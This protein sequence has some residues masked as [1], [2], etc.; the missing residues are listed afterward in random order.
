MTRESQGRDDQENQ[1]IA[2]YMDAIERGETLDHDQFLAQYPDIADELALFIQSESYF[3]RLSGT[4]NA[5]LEVSTVAHLKQDTPK[6]AQLDL[7]TPVQKPQIH[8]S[9]PVLAR[10]G[11]YELI[12]EIARGGMGVVFKAWQMSLKRFV[13]IKMILKGHLAS[14]DDVQRFQTEALAAAQLEHPGIVRIYEVNEHDGL[15]Y[16]AMAFVDGQSL[17]KRLAEG[18][19]EPRTA[20]GIVKTVCMAVQYAH[21]KGVIHRDLKPG[22]ILIDRLGCPHVTDFGLAKLMERGPDLTGTGQIL[23]TPSYMSPEQAAPNGTTVGPLSDVYSLGAILYCLLTGRPPF[24]AANDLETLV[25]VQKQDPIPPRQFNLKIPL[26][27]ETIVLKSLDKSPER[28]FVSA[29]G[30]ADELTRYLEGQPILARRISRT[31]RFWRWCQ[32]EPRVA[33]L[34]A[35]LLMVL[36]AGAVASSCFAVNERQR[37]NAVAKLAK[38]ESDALVEVEAQRKKALGQAEIARRNENLANERADNLRVFLAQKYFEHGVSEYD[39]GRPQSGITDLTRA[40]AMTSSKNPLHA[41]YRRVLVDRC[42]QGGKQLLPPL[43]HTGP[44]YVVAFSPDGTR[45]LT[46]S[47]DHLARIWDAVTG[48]PIGK[49][50]RHGQAVIGAAFSPDGSL[51]VTRSSAVA[52]LWRADNCEAVGEA[53]EHLQHINCVAFSPDGTRVVTGSDDKTARLF[54]TKSGT[55]IAE[56]MKHDGA[57]YCVAFSPDGRTVA[58]GSGVH[59]KIGTARLWDVETASPVGL[60]MRHADIVHSVCFSPDGSRLLTGSQDGDAQVWNAKSGQLTGQ[61]FAT[62]FPVGNAIFSPDGTRVLTHDGDFGLGY[63]SYF[64]RLWDAQTGERLGSLM[65]H[66]GYVQSIAFSPDGTRI[67]TGSRNKS[68]QVWDANTGKPVGEPML[69]QGYVGSVAFS[70]DGASVLSGSYDGTARLWSSEPNLPI[71]G[72]FPHKGFSSDVAF[73]PDGTSFLVGAE[74]PGGR[75]TAQMAYLRDARTGALVGQVMQHERRVLSVAYS[76]DGSLVATGSGDWDELGVAQLWDA[77]T[78]LRVGPAMKHAGRVF[79]VAFSPDGMRLATA[80]MDKT[81]RLW[82][83]RTSDPIGEPM[84]HDKNVVKLTFSPNGQFLVTGSSDSTARLWEGHTGAPIGEVM[85]HESE[86]RCVAISPDCQLI[87]TGSGDCTARLWDARNGKPVGKMMKHEDDVVS[88]AFSRDNA[89]LLTAS[90]DGTARIWDVNSNHQVGETMR[91][92]GCV[93]CAEFSPDDSRII[94]GVWIRDSTSKARLWEARTGVSI[95]TAMDNLHSVY[96]AAFSPD[97]KRTVTGSWNS[98][99]LWDTA[100]CDGDW[101]SAPQLH[102]ILKLWSGCSADS[103]GTLQV[104]SPDELDEI[105][106]RAGDPDPLRDFALLRWRRV[107]ETYHIQTAAAAETSGDWS[108][109]IFHLRQLLKETPNDLGLND[110]LVRC[111]Q[112]QSIAP[113]PDVYTSWKGWPDNGPPAAIAPFDDDTASVHQAAW[114]KHLDS[115]VEFTN[116]I[117]MKLRL[118]PPGE[119]DI[120]TARYHVRLTLPF[121]AGIH[122]VTVGQFRQFVEE[123]GYRTLAETSGLGGFSHTPDD[124]PVQKPEYIWSHLDFAST[125]NHPVAMLC[126]EDMNRFCDWLSQRESRNYRLPTEAEWEGLARAGA[127]TKFCFGNEETQLDDYAWHSRNS[128]LKSHPVGERRPNPWGLFDNYGNLIERCLDWYADWPTGKIENNPTG[129]KTGTSRVLRGISFKDNS[130]VLRA[131]INGEAGYANIGFRVILTGDVAG[132]PESYRANH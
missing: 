18:P 88:V 11:D 39:A 102:Q 132:F 45:I 22:N 37:A 123:T 34:S 113:K 108:V 1:A 71:G 101:L 61:I 79:H 104:I 38:S 117:G 109:A 129:P 92:D 59:T 19:L 50:M 48:A 13:A 85:A 118:I 78:G 106:L 21:E 120:S 64:A 51:V 42:L 10:L 53:M 5:D 89:R 121:Y 41:S 35:A 111:Q 55:R 63:H 36:L 60:V 77:R 44:V 14:S 2:E 68:V 97:S 24:Q 74:T 84:T 107:K 110:R 67:V 26:D 115:P 75:R 8:S 130:G 94:T 122:E 7:K 29:K 49:P 4:K 114:A 116:S 83:V 105:R 66:A 15:P 47:D 27:L 52:R 57:V 73:S 31:E 126:M 69:H 30:L 9:A 112:L 125:E 96:C 6:S 99:R 128:G 20:A 72:D 127:V 103:E 28:R 81:A 119:F 93:N 25:Q 3:R 86:V 43:W 40:F 54:E 131:F 12:E 87:A 91:H 100:I 95:G 56:V 65:K 33:S 17:A 32:R 124:R 82:D 62:E 80:S 46:G 98:A 23:G 70:P 16:L 90:S 76:P 58:T